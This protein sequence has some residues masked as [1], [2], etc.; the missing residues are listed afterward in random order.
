MYLLDANIFIQS[1]NLH[2]GFDIV[3][4]FWDWLDQRHAAGA[5]CSID[6]VG[7]ELDAV[8]DELTSWVKSRRRMFLAVDAATA[9]SLATLATWAASGAYRPSAISAFL[10]G[11][12]YQLVA[13]AHAHNHTV[14]THEKS[15]PASL[16]NI[17]MPDACNAMGVPCVDPFAMLRNER[18]RFVLPQG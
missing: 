9:P 2:Y 14:V 11:V 1:K 17:K 4:G 5:L 10:S 8:E 3:P 13:Y 7:E 18:A 12:D 15:S 6:K 16:T